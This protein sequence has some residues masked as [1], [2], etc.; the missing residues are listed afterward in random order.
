[1]CRLPYW[2]SPGWNA[3]FEETDY[4]ITILQLD[5]GLL[6]ANPKIILRLYPPQLDSWD[7]L[8]GAPLTQS[9]Q[10]LHEVGRPSIAEAYPER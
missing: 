3:A 7:K 1:M 8:W 5:L 9:W 2:R 6:R 10:A 4:R